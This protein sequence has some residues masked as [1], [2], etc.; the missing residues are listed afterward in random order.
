VRV[1]MLVRY[2]R[3]CG[4]LHRATGS[5]ANARTTVSIAGASSADVM[6][7]TVRDRKCT[8]WLNIQSHHSLHHTGSLIIG[9]AEASF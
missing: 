1:G 4:Q 8:S 9:L 5:A 2:C 6:V 3:E 7:L